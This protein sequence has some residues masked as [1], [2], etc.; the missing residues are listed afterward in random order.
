MLLN[1]LN[2][3][4]FK[5]H[6]AQIIIIEYIDNLIKRALEVFLSVYMPP[7]GGIKITKISN[8]TYEVESYVFM[9]C[10]ASL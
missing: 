4:Y 5:F 2:L 7:F 10:T 1:A 3:M 6:I 8:S 9:Q